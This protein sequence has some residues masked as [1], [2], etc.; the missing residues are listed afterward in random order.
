MEG[1]EVL[2]EKTDSGVEVIIR[3]PK[4]G[5]VGILL[6]LINNVS[7]ER[8]YIRLQGEQINFDDEVN[9]LNKQLR[10]IEEK[11]CVHLLVFCNGELA[12]GADIN[13]RELAQKHT[14]VFGIIL[15]KEFRG[16]GLGKLLMEQVLKE[17]KKNL[18]GLKT[19]TLECFSGNISALN[20]YKKFGFR[21][22]GILPKGLKYREE[23]Q[24]AVL[25]YLELT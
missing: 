20:L 21:E 17:G 4:A 9:W 10:L 22:Y 12:G 23:Y 24:D 13:L 1:K 2:R 8:T 7:N 16:K 25:M 14:G 6:E 19:V 15:K 3:Y 18:E 5:D 11:K